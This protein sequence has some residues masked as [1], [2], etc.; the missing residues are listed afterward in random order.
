MGSLPVVRGNEIWFYYT[1]SRTY[2]IVTSEVPDFRAICLAKLRLDG[3]VSLSAGQTPGEVVTKPLLLGTGSLHLNVDAPGGEVSA[4][5]MDSEGRHVL[6]GFALANSIPVTGDRWTPRSSGKGRAFL[7]SRQK[8]VASDGLR[9]AEPLFR[10]GRIASTA[11]VDSINPKFQR[12]VRNAL[13]ILT[14]KDGWIAQNRSGSVAVGPRC[15]TLNSGDIVCTF[16]QQSAVGIKATLT[17]VR[18]LA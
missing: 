11:T 7:V 4:E 9:K 14:I 17:N 1:G 2:G 18:D 8:P 10:L 6:E 15:A 16:M 3:F 13:E 5:I 12:T